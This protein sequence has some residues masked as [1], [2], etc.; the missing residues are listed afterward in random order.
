VLGAP[1]TL[2]AAKPSAFRVGAQTNAWPVDPK[3]IES[4]FG[5]L[6]TIKQLGYE[7]FETGFANLRGQ[8]DHPLD[9]AD[10][11]KKTGLRFLGIHVFLNTYDPQTAIASQGLLEQVA[12]GGRALGAERIIVSGGSTV[13]PLALRAKADALSKLARYCKGVGIGCAYHNHAA[14][15]QLNGIQIMGLLSQTDPS[16]HF[17]LD[18]GHA[19]AGGGNVAEFFAKNWKRIDA[20]HLRDAKGG[21]EVPLGQGDN[22]YAPLAKEVQTAGW[23]GWLVTEE[24][25]TNGDKPGEAAMKPAREAIHRVFGA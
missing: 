14:E 25:R 17:V 6:T 22:D 12:D 9:T 24:E 11:L 5:V 2:L 4:L 8:F 7:G 19:I 21:Q 13:H 15:F 18:A 1:T 23:K 3:N 20:I 10:R 16:V